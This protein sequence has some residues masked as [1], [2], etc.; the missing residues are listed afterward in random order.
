MLCALAF[1][2]GMKL[3]NVSTNISGEMPEKLDPV[4][5]YFETTH[6][7]RVKKLRQHRR[8]PL[9]RMRLQYVALL[10]MTLAYGIKPTPLSKD[11][12]RRI[13]YRRGGTIGSK[14][15]SVRTITAF[16]YFFMN[17]V[18]S[19]QILLGQR[20]RKGMDTNR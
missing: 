1:V 10:Y 15:L 11:Q 20:I 7:R 3:Y 17:C 16:T 4:V 5:D 19:E 14:W 8:D 13:I 2:P 6:K 12:R 9:N 18:R